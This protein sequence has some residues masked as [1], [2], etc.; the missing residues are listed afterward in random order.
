[1][2]IIKRKEKGL[3]ILAA[4]RS[5]ENLQEN[6]VSKRT[7]KKMEKRPINHDECVCKSENK[8]GKRVVYLA[9]GY[10]FRGVVN[11]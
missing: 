5:R 2:L 10:I 3:F 1:V 7:S 9:K 4:N 11:N 8:S 6:G